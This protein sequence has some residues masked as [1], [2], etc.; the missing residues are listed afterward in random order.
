L[1]DRSRSTFIPVAAAR[2][3]WDHSRQEP[4]RFSVEKLGDE[5][6]PRLAKYKRSLRAIYFEKAGF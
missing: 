1:D 4:F 2:F 5:H 3:H 6:T